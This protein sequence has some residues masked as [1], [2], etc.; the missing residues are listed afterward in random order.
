V[1]TFGS[2]LRGRPPRSLVSQKLTRLFRQGPF[3]SSVDDGV[4]L[5]LGATFDGK[6][7]NFALFSA[8]AT[9]VELCLFDPTGRRE[10]NRVRLPGRTDQ[11]WHG[12][13]AGLAPG[14]LYGYR[15]HG[16]YDPVHGHRFNPH[17]L[18]IDPY[19]RQLSGAIRW[20]DALFGYRLGAHRGDLTADR[21]DSAPMMPK[22][23]VEDPS[24]QWGDDRPPLC[25]W[26]DSFIYETHVKGLTQLH[27]G[28]EPKARGT[29]AALGHPAVIEHLVRLG[30]TAVELLPIHAFSD[31]RFLIEKGL[32]NYWGYSTLA[33]FAPEP[34]YLGASGIVGLKQAIRAL[35]DADI[36]VILDVVYNHTAEGN[37]L[38]PTLSFRG[39]DNR[40]YYK[41]P[42]DNPRFSWDSTGTGNTLNVSHPRVLQ[43][44]L[45]SLRH[46]VSD[47][48]VDG[49]RFDLASTL[50]RQPYDVSEHSAFLYAV[51]QDPVLS[52]AKLIA[53]P[54]DVGA[55]GYRV[56]GFPPGWSE[57][58]DQFRD[59]IRAFWRGDPGTLPALARAMTGSREIFEH[60]G[61]QPWASINYVCSHDGFTLEDLV[62]YNE[63]HNEAN[64]EDNRDGHG[65]NLSWNCG[66]EGATDDKA[67]LAL[68]ARQKRNLLATLFLSQGVPMLLMGDELSRSQKGNNNAYCQ[69]NDTSWLDW[70][71][72]AAHDRELPDFVRAL[73]ALR[74]RHDAFRRK[75]FLTGESVAGN[76][77]K[78]VYWLA[79]EGREMTQDDW[80][81]ANRRAL[82]MQ[83]GNDAPD[84][85][86]FLVLVNASADPVPF[87]I[88]VD[89]PSDRWVAVF[90]TR[91]ADGLVRGEPAALVP[92]GSLTLEGRTLT[93]LQHVSSERAS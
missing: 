74:Q 76:H 45:D 93:L 22:C 72:G 66:V 57:W 90:D 80:N 26:R 86:R 89:F 17:K 39:I 8:H 40:S 81:D 69:D 83:I 30:I 79:P 9:A 19:A 32:R 31:D 88:A 41:S 55:G 15:V 82:G 60:N 12:Y 28:I 7:V 85:G 87:A 20:H 70:K 21:R 13:I 59:T 51:G 78:D 67:I 16:P 47:Y 54:W 10:I 2:I 71:A 24:Y 58:N 6:G 27:Q 73:A 5:P 18:L 75:R 42:P 53:E 25:A 14:Q 61:R 91:L 34:R 35:H 29:Y 11:I 56:G 48:H 38:G 43:M 50:L 84:G 37:Y 1:S 33:F 52:R 44:V 68:R 63:R 4:P 77:L 46:W 62:S 92:G 3:M 23:V 36:E 64:Q 49:F 65:H